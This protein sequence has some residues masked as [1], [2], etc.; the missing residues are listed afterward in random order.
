MIGSNP[1]ITILL[2]YINRLHTN[3]SLSETFL[4]G[5]FCCMSLCNRTETLQPFYTVICG[6]E[7][8]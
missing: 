2:Y 1:V 6:L 4:K 5:Y 8:L 3:K 7:Y